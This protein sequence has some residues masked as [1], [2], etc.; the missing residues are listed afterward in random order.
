M[1][2]KNMSFEQALEK[3]EKNVKDLE[4]G[5]LSLDEVLKLFEEGVGLVKV[6]QQKINE[7]E[8]KI[9]ILSSDMREAQKNEGRLDESEY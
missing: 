1:A 2:A 4:S 5:D 3:L 8:Q 9:E 7:A 6:C